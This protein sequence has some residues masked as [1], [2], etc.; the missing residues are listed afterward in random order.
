MRVSGRIEAAEVSNGSVLIRGY[1][2]DHFDRLQFELTDGNVVLVDTVPR[3]SDF[4][5]AQYQA[6]FKAESP[7]RFIKNV[8]AQS[9]GTW[10]PAAAGDLSPN[11]YRWLFQHGGFTAETI[12]FDISRP[13]SRIKDLPSLA[14]YSE[15]LIGE[16]A[17]GGIH[18][19]SEMAQV[20]TVLMYRI[21][22]GQYSLTEQGEHAVRSIYERHFRAARK[23]T[24]RHLCSACYAYA[25]YRLAS[26][27]VAGAIEALEIVKQGRDS[28]PKN[29]IMSYNFVKSQLLLGLILYAGGRHE[30]A[31]ACC[32]DV[33]DVA[34]AAPTHLGKTFAMSTEIEVIFATCSEA[35]KLADLMS[36][37]TVYNTPARRKFDSFEALSAATRAKSK[38]FVTGVQALLFPAA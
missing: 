32:R 31:T 7:I 6:S 9:G 15:Y 38:D 1:L 5:G 30:E 14:Q 26:N 16:M 28:I 3:G 11:C 33:V 34:Y 18:E 23:A 20:L 36:G 27:D 21:A 25:H 10:V 4:P 12:K 19:I 13:A 22:A 37:A 8:K 24:D 35:M 17:S 2:D 29:G